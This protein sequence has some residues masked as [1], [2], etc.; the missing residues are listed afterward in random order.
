MT[1]ERI[2]FFDLES[3]PLVGYTWGLWEQNVI[4]KIQD[5]FILCAAYKWL[6]DKQV[7]V[8]SQ[9]D[10]PKYSKD[11]KDDRVVV[12]KI[13]ELLNEA[14]IVIAHNGRAFDI[15]KINSRFLI[16][17]FSP[18]SPYK[19]IDTLTVARSNF[20]FDSN[21]LD[22][23]GEVLHLGRKVEHEGIELWLSCMAGDME[24]WKRMIKYNKQ[25]VALLEELYLELRPW[26]TN[27]PTFSAVVEEP[28]HCR[29]PHCNST[30]IQKRGPQR[31]SGGRIQQR[32]QCMTCF[33]WM[34]GKAYAG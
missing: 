24:A 32:Y 30:H 9:I 4:K 27:H 13:W 6:G 20:K 33:S 17:G 10:S 7:S 34:H 15:K 5:S 14:D 12:Q 16:L 29:I 19:V 18:P 1:K 8:V 11:R 3:T 25:D 28:T 21:K 2:L 22:S 23:L 31:L 26:I